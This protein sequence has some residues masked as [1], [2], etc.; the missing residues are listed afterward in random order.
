MS[1]R[2]NSTVSAAKRSMRRVRKVDSRQRGS[3]AT[4]AN[5][6]GAADQK[7]HRVPFIRPDGEGED[8]EG[9][10]AQHAQHGA[11]P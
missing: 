10:E 3:D 1:A 6:R 9:G 8:G 11:G 5:R 2:P 4:A 7:R